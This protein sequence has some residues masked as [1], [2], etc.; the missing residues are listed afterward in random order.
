MGDL[1]EIAG[2]LESVNGDLIQKLFAIEAGLATLPQAEIPVKHY[3]SNGVY[4]REISVPA[5]S[6][7]IGKM[8]RFSQI[9]I[10]TKG[11]MSVLTENG[12]VRMTAGHTFDS[13]AGIKRA[14]YAHEDTVWTTICG[15]DETDT[16]KID[17]VLTI[18]TYAEYLELKEQLLIE[19]ET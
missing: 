3:F 17:E 12:W 9:N 18:G 1:R 10:V 6:L 19:K 2:A 8:H 7:I 4:A 13:P 5:G 11:D 15:T 14:G 16:D